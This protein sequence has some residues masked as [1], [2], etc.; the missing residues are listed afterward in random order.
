MTS[1][2]PDRRM[3]STHVVTS[4][5]RLAGVAVPVRL[6]EANCVA[7]SSSLLKYSPS[8]TVTF[9]DIGFGVVPM[10]GYLQFIFFLNVE[11][12]A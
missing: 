4:L 1:R 11:K 7:K 9:H 12:I 3:V 8:T 10:R 5:G 6:R 2:R